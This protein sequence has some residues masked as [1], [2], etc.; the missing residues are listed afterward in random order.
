M[1]ANKTGTGDRS[2][3]LLDLIKKLPTTYADALA[4]LAQILA[5]KIIVEEFVGNT[6]PTEYKFDVVNGS[7]AAIDIVEGRDGDCPCYAVVDTD[8]NRLDAFGC[9]EPRGI[10]H[11]DDAT[12]CT[13]IDFETGKR[14][15]GSIKKEIYTCT[16]VVEIDQC[17]LTEMTE[18]ALGLGNRICAYY[19]GEHVCCRQ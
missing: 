13:A 1:L 5:T 10:G 7:I 19:A 16:E 14:K 11:V 18:I 15:A 3:P 17:L 8:W 6:L 2:D 9:F 4:M 12:S